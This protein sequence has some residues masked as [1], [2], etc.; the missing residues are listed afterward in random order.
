MAEDEIKIN[1]MASLEDWIEGFRKTSMLK[2]PK[3]VRMT[4][5]F[6]D[7]DGQTEERAWNHKS[8]DHEG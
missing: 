8:Y 2:N 4:A 1:P 3:L 6:R 7:D 5:V